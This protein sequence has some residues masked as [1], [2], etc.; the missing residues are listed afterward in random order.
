[1]DVEDKTE[2][3]IVEE[4]DIETTPGARERFLEVLKKEKGEDYSPEGD[5]ELWEE[6]SKR[7]DNL[8]GTHLKT[9]EMQSKLVEK[10][11]EDP[12][13]GLFISE[14]IR[15]TSVPKAIGM[16]YGDIIDELQDADLEDYESGYTANKEKRNNL[17]KE[18]EEQ[19]KNAEKFLD[20]FVKYTQDK[21]YD[22]AKADELYDKVYKSIS[23]AIN[24]NVDM[25]FVEYIDKG[26]T[27][28]KDVQAAATTGVIEGKNKK[29]EATLKEE[30]E[31]PGDGIPDLDA[32][33]AQDK[34]DTRKPEPFN[35]RGLSMDQFPSG[36]TGGKFL[37]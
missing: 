17:L 28:D 20:D 26:S 32:A 15:G 9:K 34:G 14:I 12:S 1:M 23:D 29:I 8:K 25:K 27:Y 3:T 33:T 4:K 18:A 10:L 16:V 11:N 31:E 36:G 6:S 7:W 2:E 19:S 5:D 21:G 35:R 37:K 30:I 13:L 24:G 22:E